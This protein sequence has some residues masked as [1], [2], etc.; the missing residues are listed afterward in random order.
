MVYHKPHEHGG[1]HRTDGRPGTQ[2]MRNGG[3]Y[4]GCNNARYITCIEQST[5]YAQTPCCQQGH[6]HAHVHAHTRMRTRTHAR[7]CI[8]TCMHPHLRLRPHTCVPASTSL[9][10]LPHLHGDH[11]D[12][13]GQQHVY[14]ARCPSHQQRSSDANVGAAVACVGGTEKVGGGGTLATPMSVPLWPLWM[15]QRKRE[16]EER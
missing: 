9:P 5:M 10:S 15:G 1:V 4:R 11:P 16:A 14:G 2:C 8:W 12:R 6:P 3:K 13:V 7:A